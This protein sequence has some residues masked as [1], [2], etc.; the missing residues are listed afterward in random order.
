MF[1]RMALRSGRFTRRLFYEQGEVQ[2]EFLGWGAFH[3]RPLVAEPASVTAFEQIEER[4]AVVTLHHRRLLV[5]NSTIS[6]VVSFS[7][8]NAWSVETVAAALSFSM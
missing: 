7:V 2:P 8:E 1:C 3:E 6:A 4:P 5:G